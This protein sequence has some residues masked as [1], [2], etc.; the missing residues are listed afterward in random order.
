MSSTSID[1]FDRFVLPLAPDRIN[2]DAASA[3]LDDLRQCRVDGVL[4]ESISL[5]QDAEQHERWE[6]DSPVLVGLEVAPQL[7]C[8]FPD[9]RRLVRKT[10]SHCHAE[11]HPLVGC[12]IGV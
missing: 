7:V 5:R 2:A 11:P 6:H 4:P 9:E 8:D 3:L 10:L 12:R 1:E